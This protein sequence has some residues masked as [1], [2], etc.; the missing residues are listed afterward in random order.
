MATKG[1]KRF[2]QMKRSTSFAKGD[3]RHRG[4]K[5]TDKKDG[6]RDGKFKLRVAPLE[7][8]SLKDAD[9]RKR[10]VRRFRALCR[11]FAAGHDMRDETIAAI[12]RNCAF[13]TMETELIQQQRIEGLPIRQSV[14]VRVANTLSRAIAT[15][16]LVKK[17]YSAGHPSRAVGKS[18]R[19][20]VETGP[21]PLAQHLARMHSESIRKA[22]E[23]RFQVI[24]N[25]D[26]A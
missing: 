8:P 1:K 23:R 3:G 26:T 24:S 13:L 20:R 21:S 2:P 7:P 12:V 15:L 6:N 19:D 10:N 25:T 4:P 14:A 5:A 22:Q 18:T 11:H 17:G 16:A 9:R